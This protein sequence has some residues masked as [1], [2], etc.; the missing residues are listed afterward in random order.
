MEADFL[1]VEADLLLCRDLDLGDRDFEDRLDLLG[2]GT[3]WSILQMGI[4]GDICSLR[5]PAVVAARCGV[6][7]PQGEGVVHPHHPPVYY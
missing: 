1:N 4:I 2:L 3:L 7:G 6:V 5:L